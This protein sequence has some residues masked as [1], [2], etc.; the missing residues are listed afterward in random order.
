MDNLVGSPGDW[1]LPWPLSEHIQTSQ[2]QS[3]GPG[4][5]CG[6]W[7]WGDCVLDLHPSL[8]P[9][10]VAALIRVLRKKLNSGVTVSPRPPGCGGERT[11][12]SP[13]K[14][15][16]ECVGSAL[17]LE[18]PHQRGRRYPVR[19]RNRFRDEGQGPQE[20]RVTWVG[21]REDVLWEHQ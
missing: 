19:E 5:K 10:D 21:S 14:G 7:A 3:K 15:A 9:S 11:R 8:G 12:E 20:S 4:L 18:H 16:F 6:N 13:S 2:P 17:G 1:P